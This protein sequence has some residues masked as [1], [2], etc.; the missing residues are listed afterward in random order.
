MEIIG[1]FIS[2]SDDDSILSPLE[3]IQKDRQWKNGEDFLNIDSAWGALQA[4]YYAQES[5]ML[6][7]QGVLFR[8]GPSLADLV[9]GKRGHYD[10]VFVY[11]S[12]DVGS[13]WIAQ[14][15]EEEMLEEDFLKGLSTADFLDANYYLKAKWNERKDALIQYNKAI[16]DFMKRSYDKKKSVLY[17]AGSV[18]SFGSLA[19]NT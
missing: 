11:R 14:Y 19:T 17:V 4:A 6:D 16:L 15:G 8:S 9:F 12:F 2:I 13:S 1:M 10:Q 18:E 5:I 3:I 7:K